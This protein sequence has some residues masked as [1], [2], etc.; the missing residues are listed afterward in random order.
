MVST[1]HRTTQLWFYGTDKTKGILKRVY[2]E[3]GVKV[4]KQFFASGIECE[5]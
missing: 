4:V 3:W 5:N 2:V 1:A